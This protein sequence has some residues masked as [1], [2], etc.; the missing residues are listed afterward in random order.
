M[1]RYLLDANVLIAL[2]DPA[3]VQPDEM[4]ESSSGAGSSEP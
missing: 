1:I 3:H 2:V 4:R